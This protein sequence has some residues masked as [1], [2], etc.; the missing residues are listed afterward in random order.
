MV[1]TSPTERLLTAN[2][3]TPAFGKV[4]PYL[5]GREEIIDDIMAAFEQPDGN[6]NS[7]SIFVGARGTGKTALLT[8]LANEA[9]S[10]RWISANVTAS[11]G[12]LEDILERIGESATHLIVDGAPKRKLTGIEIAPLGG[13]SWENAPGAP[14][15]WRTRMN[16]IFDQLESTDTGILIT[17]DE[18]DPSLD[19]MTRLATTYQHFVRE[20]KRAMLL[21]AGLPHRVHAL[22]SGESTSFLRR[23]A[24]HNL[25]SIPRYEIEDA[26]RLTVASGGKTIEDDALSAA[27]DAIDGFPFM[28]QLV[29]FRS[30]NASGRRDAI[31][32]EDVRRGT[33]LAQSELKDR[34][35]DATFAELSKGD[36]AFLRAMA[37]D[38]GATSR[39]DLMKRLGKTS[40][41]V[42]TYK[43]RL[44]EAG[45]IEEPQRG[46][47]T[48]ALPGMRDYMRELEA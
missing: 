14:T 36:R 25:G 4:P 26:F 37:Q 34:V 33:E 27:A 15:N 46:M 48:F 2:P 19:E 23:A 28:F 10:R 5:A 43:K 8:Y 41:Y 7:C 45:V 47:F 11:A 32:L 21:M 3:F 24:R 40:S 29:G 9:E 20:G 6:P 22:V 44:L 30:W 35:L 38:N 17:V 18:V 1:G 42:S 16:R 31:E 13:V 12:M 39:E